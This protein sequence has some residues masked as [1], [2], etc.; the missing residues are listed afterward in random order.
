MSTITACTA[1]HPNYPGLTCNL[2]HEPGTSHYA[3]GCTWGGPV[4][5]LG[6]CTRNPGHGPAEVPWS[7][8]RLCWDCADAELD[9]MA[10]AL[11]D[12]PTQVGG[13][14]LGHTP[15]QS[16]GEDKLI[17]ALA[18]DLLALCDNNVSRISKVLAV[19]S[20]DEV[21]DGKCGRGCAA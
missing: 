5:T 10:K 17:E 12:E 9:L 14:G 21:W 20:G 4:T 7:G 15:A 1:E 16:A 13:F 11:E 8:E 19:L 3:L 18:A 2:V 6:A